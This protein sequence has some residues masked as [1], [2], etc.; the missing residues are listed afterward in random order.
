QEVI[1]KT[2]IGKIQRAQ[3]RTRFEAGE[4]GELL[5]RM[6]IE[7]ANAN[8]LP[9]WFFE[10][11]WLR[12]KARLLSPQVCNGPYLIFGDSTG[13]AAALSA[14]LSKCGERAINVEIGSEYLQIRPELYRINSEQATDYNR[15]LE[16][17]A[18]DGTHIKTVIHLWSYDKYRGE[19]ASLD[20]LK[21]A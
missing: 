9:D 15:L 11:K 14:E 16:S 20:A 1:P 7:S 8:T 4:F 19:V 21:H 6:D 3:L 5:K 12:K 2:A 13:L 10:R 18:T 17:I